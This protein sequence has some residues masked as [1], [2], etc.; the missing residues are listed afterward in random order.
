M[1][2]LSFVCV[3]LSGSNVTNPTKPVLNR[4]HNV[5]EMGVD[6]EEDPCGELDPNATLPFISHH[7]L[8]L[9]RDLVP[10]SESQLLC[11]QIPTEQCS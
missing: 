5:Y 2:C 9:S 6:G 8:N 4:T 1:L 3:A 11:L 10:D 7:T